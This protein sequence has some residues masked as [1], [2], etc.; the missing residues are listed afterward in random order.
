[1]GR[2]FDW[3]PILQERLS[4]LCPLLFCLL[5]FNNILLRVSVFQAQRTRGRVD[6]EA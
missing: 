6:N 3:G 4:L 1:M 2:R 5:C